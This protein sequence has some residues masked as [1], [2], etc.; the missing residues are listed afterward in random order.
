[1]VW[2]A[3]RLSAKGM[4]VVE[5]FS[6]TGSLEGLLVVLGGPADNLVSGGGWAPFAFR[7][8]PR[9]RRRLGYALFTR[10]RAGTQ[11]RHSLNITA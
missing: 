7:V 4:P 1:M 11:L 10:S 9:G 6:T 5:G 3:E 2:N 8:S